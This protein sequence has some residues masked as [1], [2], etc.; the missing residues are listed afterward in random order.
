MSPRHVHLT[1]LEVSG[2]TAELY[3]NGVPLVR[4]D[5]TLYPLTNA[6]AEEYLVGGTNELE[7][8]VE[9]GRHPSSTRSDTRRVP[10][11]PM[12][13]VARVLKVPD[14]EPGTVDYGETVAETV[15]G[16]AQP[17]PDERQV[18]VTT[19]VAFTMPRD[20][21]GWPWQDASR[22][23][24]DE[25]LVDEACGVL[26]VLEDAL[27]RGDVS[28]VLSLVEAKLDD[29]LRGYPAHPRA[30]LED[31]L[32]ALMVYVDAADDP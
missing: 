16:W 9:P 22:L 12:K 21:G 3:L 30:S 19:S 28:A 29:V 20:R 10:F 8:L 2:C 32:R 11:R 18:P 6:A 4:L 1:Q 23:T 24:L 13:A 14:G 7:V 31:E 25:R 5:P 15:F 27:R 26:D 17:P